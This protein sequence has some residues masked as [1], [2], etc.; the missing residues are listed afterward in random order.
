MELLAPEVG[1]FG[2][3]TTIV[4][5]GFFRAELLTE[6]STKYAGVAGT[7]QLVGV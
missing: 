5:P 7:L 2:I 1:P 3:A 4:N 6:R